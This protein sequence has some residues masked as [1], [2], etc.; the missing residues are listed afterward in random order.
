[1]QGLSASKKN[2]K[3]Y[4]KLP[5]KE[6]E[7]KPWDVLCVDP[8][9]HYQFMPKGGAKKYQ[10]TTKN[11]KTAYLQVVTM[12]GQA[13]GWIEILTVPTTHSDLVPNII[14]IP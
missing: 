13:T 5:P 9:G 2:K 12:I 4:E 7:R 10:M 11:R 3:Q 6:A 1:M 8:M 14:E